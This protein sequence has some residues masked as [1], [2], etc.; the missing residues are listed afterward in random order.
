MSAEADERPPDRRHIHVAEGVVR[1]DLPELGAPLFGRS[2]AG[3]ET[4]LAVPAWKLAFDVGRA[5]KRVIP[6]RHLAL[7]HA[8]A[9]HSGGL[10]TWLAMRHLMRLGPSHVYLPAPIAAP[11]ERLVAGWAALQGRPWPV[12]FHA[13][14]PG[15][16]RSLGAGLTLEALRTHHVVPT[17]GWA[18]RQRVQKLAPAW[19][20]EPGPVI[21]EARRRGAEV[22]TVDE[23]LLLAVS[24]DTMASALD[25][26][27]AFLQAQV[28]VFETTFLDERH[29]PAHAHAGGHTHLDELCSEDRRWACGVLVPYH[30]SQR[31]SDERARALIATR[32]PEGLAARAVPLLP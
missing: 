19:H 23:R 3:V 32:L 2:V 22:H 24:G 5:D 17:L 14:E 28:T 6:C 1:L 30:I 15:D 10:I 20:G 27:P 13:M 29:P 31:Y 7:T 9:D 26:S 25:S 16:T 4:W 21:A 8:H 12:T 18:V 11:L